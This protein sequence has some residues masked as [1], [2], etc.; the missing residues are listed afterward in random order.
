MADNSQNIILSIVPAPLLPA[1]SGGQKATYGPLDALGKIAN[2]V[3]VT[4]TKSTIENHTFELKPLIKHSPQKYFS[5]KNYKIILSQVKQ[6]KPKAI[7]LEQPFMGFIIYCISQKTKTPYFIHSHNIEYLRF[8]SLGKSWWPIL[9]FIERFTLQRAAGVFFITNH[10]RDLAIH[11]L[12]I[13]EKQCYVAPYGVPQ[14]GLI[15]FSEQKKIAV[16]EKHGITP[17]ETVFMFFGVLKYMPNIEAL[18]LIIQEIL[19]RLISKLDKKFKIL[20]C[21][22]GISDDYK[23][24]LEELDPEHFIYAGF[25]DDIDDYTQSA[26]IILNPVLSG[27]GIKTKIVEALGF[28]KNVISTKT[29]AIGVDQ[30]ICGSKLYI[31][32]DY[33]W[34][35]F[36]D[37]AILAIDDQS[38]IPLEFF[39]MFSW[40]SIS[41]LILNNLTK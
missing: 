19:P 20:I 30:N 17:D 35:S 9:Y 2:I 1:V 40:K 7:L 6:L 36:V 27:G 4:D 21:G 22:A 5:I 33:D 23:K 25:V 24:Q 3:C 37:K 14:D 28:N 34:D 15:N 12:G 18:E 26:D 31:V 10:D 38:D 32:D 13:S 39:K 11:N 8:K 16:R 29:G 41:Q